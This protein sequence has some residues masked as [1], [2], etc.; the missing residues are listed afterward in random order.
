MFCCAVLYA[1]VAQLSWMYLCSGLLI[2]VFMFAV[3]F[4]MLKGWVCIWHFLF[5]RVPSAV[6]GAICV[7]IASI[8][9]VMYGSSSCLRWNPYVASV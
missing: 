2:V 6:F 7:V 1:I 9:F 3:S 8:V 5:M 4:L